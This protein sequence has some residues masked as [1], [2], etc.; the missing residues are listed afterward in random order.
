[1]PQRTVRSLANTILVVAAAVWAL[2]VPV[3]GV[4]TEYEYDKL[5]RTIFTRSDRFGLNILSQTGYD[6]V[7]Q[8]FAETNETDLPSPNNVVVTRFGY[9]AL[10]RL[11][12][13]TN[14]YG[15]ADQIHTLYAYNPFGELLSQTDANNHTTTFAYDQFGQRIKRTLPNGNYEELFYNAGGNMIRQNQ[16]S[17]PGPSNP[18]RIVEFRYDAL[19]RLTNKFQQGFEHE[20]FAQFVYNASGQ[21]LIVTNANGTAR[22]RTLYA[23]DLAG[24]LATRTLQFPN[25]GDRAISYTYDERGHIFEAL[26]P[27]I[28]K[29]HYGWN[30]LNQLAGVTNA[31]FNDQEGTTLYGYDAIGNLK[32]VS[33]RKAGADPILATL[34]SSYTYD[35]VNRLDLM[36]VNS[37][38]GQTVTELANFDYVL[39]RT[40]K[41]LGVT[42]FISAGVNRTVNYSYDYLDRLT[43]EEIVAGVPSGTITYDAEPGY[44]EPTGIGYDKVGNRRSRDV[45]TVELQNAGVTDYTGKEFDPNDQFVGVAYDV[46]G[47]TLDEPLPSPAVSPSAAFPDE[48]DFENRLT[49]RRDTTLII[50]LQYDGDGN[51]IRK[52]V[53]D[54]APEPDIVTTTTYIVDELNPTGYS[55]VLAETST[56]GTATTTIRYTYGHDLISATIMPVTPYAPPSTHWYGYDGHGSVRFLV[57]HQGDTITDTY[58]YDAFGKMNSTRQP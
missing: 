47:N 23:Y 49:R 34:E 42:E 38:V 45:S 52:I 39:G 9:D 3:L 15:A 35:A 55:Q 2:W 46:N 13:V 40:P 56:Q 33:S 21:R 14:A 50:D 30:A 8:R 41:R 32:T 28:G 57:T 20:R 51:R 22:G 19:N 27:E 1:L 25:E 4:V 5:N 18:Q 37:V 16:F 36:R 11:T 12:A 53:R 58:T 29:V 48:Y 6:A 44:S 7:G 26:V 24:R 31:P 54:T 43:K 17:P 10:G